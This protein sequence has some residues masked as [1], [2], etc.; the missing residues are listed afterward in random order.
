MWSHSAIIY[1]VANNPAII[2]PGIQALEEF[3]YTKSAYELP[4]VRLTQ[5]QLSEII[6]L[7]GAYKIIA[8]RERHMLSGAAKRIYVALNRIF[9]L[10]TGSD[11][12]Y[13]S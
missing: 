13:L 4:D 10:E 2:E 9:K 12:S 6:E 3:V 7:I 8:D 1:H 11:D 5:Q